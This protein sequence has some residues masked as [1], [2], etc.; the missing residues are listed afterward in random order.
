M[1]Y[2]LTFILLVNASFAFDNLKIQQE[3]QLDPEF[4]NV[5][6]E[7]SKT[8]AL[9]SLFTQSKK[10]KVLKRPLKSS[11]RLIFDRSIGVFWELQKPFKSTIVIDKDKL[12]SIDDDGKKITIK[13]EEKPMLYGFTKIFLAIF[14]GNTKELKEHFEIYYGKSSEGWKIGLIPKSSSLK[15]V[16]SKIL[17]IGSE[18][19]VSA[20]TLWEENGDITN[21][22]FS[23][24]QKLDKLDE[25]DRRKFEF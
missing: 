4:K 21:I 15:K 14:S 7:L 22:E 20:I 9:K 10:I 12:T 2:L 19:T 23:K 17:L 1:K 5:S 6:E 25:N 18:S 8:S 3:G 24:T 16:L 11:G 13:A